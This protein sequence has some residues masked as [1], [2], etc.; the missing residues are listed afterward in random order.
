MVL[1]HCYYDLGYILNLDLKFILQLNA[2]HD[3]YTPVF[4]PKTQYITPL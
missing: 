1:E 3:S 2:P 4:R